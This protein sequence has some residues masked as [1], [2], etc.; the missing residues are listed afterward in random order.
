MA[1]TV[2]N[3]RTSTASGNTSNKYLFVTDT[4]SNESTKIALDNVFP[5][6]QSGLTVGTVTPGSPGVLP[7]DMFVGG[8]SGS[9]QANTS[10]SVLIFKGLGVEDSASNGGISIRTDISTSDPNKQNLV[11]KLAQN[12]IDLSIAQNTTSK[13]ISESTGT[14]AG[15]DISIVAG[16]GDG[17]ADGGQDYLQYL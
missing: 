5:S 2:S 7:L 6:L 3:L 14:N 16:Q 13:F 17:N 11:I 4:A 8:G 15:G 10:K 9:A 12:K 1:K